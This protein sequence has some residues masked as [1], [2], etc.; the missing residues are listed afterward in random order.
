MVEPADAPWKYDVGDFAENLKDGVEPGAF[1]TP[2][3]AGVDQVY[4][5]IERASVVEAMN[6]A[7]IFEESE[8]A[9]VLDEWYH[10]EGLGSMTLREQGKSRRMGN[11][12]GRQINRL[13]DF[14][15]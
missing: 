5:E 13:E 11:E 8:I 7:G 2:A 6:D 10:A 4:N 1:Y 9:R 15:D 3:T 12:K 14:H